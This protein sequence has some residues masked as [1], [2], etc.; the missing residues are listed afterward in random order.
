M[1]YPNPCYNVVCY[2]GLALYF[3]ALYLSNKFLRFFP[4]G[5]YC[6]GGSASAIA[7]PAGTF[8][9]ASGLTAVS[10]CTNCTAGSYC[11][12]PGLLA[13]EGKDKRVKLRISFLISQPKHMLL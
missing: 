12:T 8:G 3:T 13:V 7:C 5:F 10:E 9:A 6:P 11:E 2:K 1:L 4:A